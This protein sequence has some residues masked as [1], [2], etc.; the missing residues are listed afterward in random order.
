ML[1]INVG[2]TDF[3]SIAVAMQHHLTETECYSHKL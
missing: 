3:S 2:Y 1:T